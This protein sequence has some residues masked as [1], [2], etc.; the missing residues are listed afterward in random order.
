MMVQ[1]LIKILYF[2]I[3]LVIITI[4]V[5]D[6]L[7]FYSG[8]TINRIADI[9][10]LVIFSLIFLCFHIIKARVHIDE[11]TIP[12]NLTILAIL[13][14]ANFILSLLIQFF[15]D[16][17]YTAG[18]PPAY[19]SP[20]GVFISTL[21]ALT[22]SLTL[23]PAF[24]ILKQLIFHKRKRNTAILFNIYLFAIT[25]NA[26]FV[27]YTEQPVG[28][29]TFSSESLLNDLSFSFALICV[30]LLSFRNEW[31]TF[32]PRKRKILYFFLGLPLLVA[33]GALFDIVYRHSLPAY[34]L[35]IAALTFNMWIFLLIYA[36]LAT[37]K[38]L[39]QIPTARVFDRKIKELNSLYDLGRMLN[40]ETK[41]PKLLPLITQLTSKVLESQSA[42][43]VLYDSKEN[44][45]S[46]SS[47]V[48]L[49]ESE[50]SS[51]PFRKLD[52]LNEMIVSRKE[53][54]LINDVRHHSHFKELLQWK[55]DARTILG[56]PLF[57]NRGQLMGIIYATKS[58][59]YTFDIDDKSL[60]QGVANQGSVA[61][62][63]ARLLQESIVRE[64][65]EQELKIARDV[66]LKLLPQTLPR[67]EN[68][69]LEAFCLSA[70]EVGGDYYDYFF[71]SDGN[72]GIIIGDVSGKGTSAAL[73]MAE[74]K[75]IIQTLA[76]SHNSPYSL[77]CGINQ[78]IYPNIER[79]TFISAIIAKI[80]FKKERIIFARA[81]HTPVLFC[82][83]NGL[84][85][86]N[87]ITKG[88]GIGLD[89]GDKFNRLLEEYTV[90]L[91]GQGTMIFY[92]DGVTE[93]RNRDGTEYGEDRL[94][95]L[96]KEC[97]ADKAEEIKERIV[98]SVI[99][100]CGDT[101]LHDDLTFIVL[102]N[103]RQTG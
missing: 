101:P 29:M 37:L 34:S 47:P 85:P 55:Q 89:P 12:Q 27:Y 62:E 75:G 103:C 19:N 72:P 94:V 43:L 32:L 61:I 81:G 67:I 91:N 6:L 18:F 71:F 26:F 97:R 35:S 31:I 36:G 73:Y 82:G 78:I 52:G 83:G 24:F 53:A 63:N 28:W 99:E 88:I 69:D 95:E 60:M 80:D 23:V 21:M 98:N 25:L 15:F 3:P 1:K 41:L 13:I 64:R 76:M 65:M 17:Q 10:E 84:D 9:R 86:Q 22:A 92:T 8:I 48:Q 56:A 30:I 44:Q 58:K 2:F 50:V 74:F 42:W 7:A 46:L 39:S 77:A 20:S 45:F 5:I 16:P 93:A 79:R 38:L 96:F 87:I 68:F 49:S 51:V 59:E 11:Q 70:Y 4:F 14:S 90:N 54:V 33:I 100:F 102:K 57:S 66:Q 40:S